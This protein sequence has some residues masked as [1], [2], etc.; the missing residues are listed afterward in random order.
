ML[1]DVAIQ[2]CQFKDKSCG[3]AD[4][5]KALKHNIWLQYKTYPRIKLNNMLFIGIRH[6]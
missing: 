5:R 2:G 6:A 4:K 1:Q 3:N